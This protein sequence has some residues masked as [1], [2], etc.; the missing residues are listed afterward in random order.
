MDFFQIRLKEGKKDE[1]PTEVYPEF[2]VRRSSDLMVQSGKFY[3]VWD[4]EEGLWSRDEYRV[5]ILVDRALKLEVERLSSKTNGIVYVPSLLENNSTR[6][7]KEFIDYVKTLGNNYHALDTRVVFA[8]TEVKKADHA[9]R[10]LPYNMAPGSIAAY[11]EL[12]SM[13]Y[14]PEE[15]TKFEWG[16]GAI[17]TGDSKKIEKFFVFH[18]LG[19]TGKSTIMKIIEM[20]FGG[21]VTDG[22]YVAMFEA[23]SLVGGNSAFGMEAFRAN[24]LVGI[25]HDGDLSKIEDN[26]RL[27]SIVSHEMMTVNEKFKATYD[28]RINAMLFMGTNKQV[29]ISDAKSGLIRRLIDIYPTGKTHTVPA[30]DGADPVRAR[31]NR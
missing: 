9:S 7:N 4:A 13:L 29:Q 28:S 25:Q 2:I 30:V 3:A 11:E 15:R 14:E 10:R 20:L 18:G 27:N 22:G 6:R 21:N 31:R 19:G 23:Q 1:D 8:N 5:P 26:S 17:I 16:I 12:V 24:P